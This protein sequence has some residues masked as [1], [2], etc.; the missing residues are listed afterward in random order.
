MHLCFLN[1]QFSIRANRVQLFL[2]EVFVVQIFFV[3][4]IAIASHP[5]ILPDILGDDI[6]SFLFAAAMKHLSNVTHQ[7]VSGPH[8]YMDMAVD[9]TGHNEFPVEIF[10]LSVIRRKSVLIANIDELSVLHNKCAG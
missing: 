6:Q 1:L 8:G 5:G 7:L 10:H 2:R 4:D 3:E 9:N